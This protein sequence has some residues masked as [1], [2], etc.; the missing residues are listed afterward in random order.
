MEQM[1]RWIQYVI[2]KAEHPPKMIKDIFG[3][4]NAKK[5]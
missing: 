2:A 1:G 4:Q 5:V 3:G